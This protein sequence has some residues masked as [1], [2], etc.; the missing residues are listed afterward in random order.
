MASAELELGAHTIDELCDAITVFFDKKNMEVAR[1][2]DKEKNLYVLNTQGKDHTPS[3][4]KCYVTIES[5]DDGKVKISAGKGNWT[6]KIL[7]LAKKVVIA[8]VFPP[9]APV[10]ILCA[11]LNVDDIA[12]QYTL[13]DAVCVFAKTFLEINNYTKIEKIEQP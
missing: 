2:Y 4:H 6:G 13:P 11:L 3:S 8:T 10:E 1:G 12:H 9:L 5:K 7:D